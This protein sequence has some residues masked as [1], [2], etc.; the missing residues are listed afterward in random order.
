MEEF[1]LRGK[2]V[3]LCMRN[4]PEYIIGFFAILAL[5]G[6]VIPLDPAVGK[7]RFRSIVKQVQPKLILYTDPLDY[8]TGVPCLK[9]NLDIENLV[10]SGFTGHRWKSEY[11]SL[12]EEKAII[13]YSSG[14]T[15]EPKGGILTHD[16]LLF[17]AETLSGIVSMDPNHH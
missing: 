2:R 9:M 16:Q 1:D 14:S 4:C 15:G 13:L 10:L 3:I 12:H 11:E 8:S 7:K 17:I 5:E 6:I